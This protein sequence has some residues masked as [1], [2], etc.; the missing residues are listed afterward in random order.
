VQPEHGLVTAAV[1]RRTLSAL[2]DT[3]GGFLDAGLPN[4]L[5]ERLDAGR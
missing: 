5:A 3:W 2:L 4:S 1:D